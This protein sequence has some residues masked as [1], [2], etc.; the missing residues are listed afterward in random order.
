MTNSIQKEKTMPAKSGKQLRYMAGVASG[1]IP[2]PKGLSSKTAA[3]FVH[4]TPKGAFTSKPKKP[5]AMRPTTNKPNIPKAKKPFNPFMRKS[6][7][8]SGN[9]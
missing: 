5:H 8:T 7:D 1:S 6:L 4:S 3:E 9:F 2:A